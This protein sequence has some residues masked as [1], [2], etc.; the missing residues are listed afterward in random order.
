[1]F[2]MMDRISKIG[3]LWKPVIGKGFNLEKAIKA[4]EKL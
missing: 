3:D 1:M 2:N 4:M